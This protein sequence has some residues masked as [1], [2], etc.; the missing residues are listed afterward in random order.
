MELCLAKVADAGLCASSSSQI[1]HTEISWILPALE[2][3]PF[4][5][6]VFEILRFVVRVSVVIKENIVVVQRSEGPV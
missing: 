4:P 6:T 5:E 2:I 3:V 1:F